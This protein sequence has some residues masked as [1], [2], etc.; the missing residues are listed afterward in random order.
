MIGMSCTQFGT[1]DPMEI[2][3][4]VSQDFKHWEIFSEDKHNVTSDF[5]TKFNAIKDSFSMKYSIHAPICDINI[6]ALNKEIRNTSVSEI[7]KTVERANMMGIRTVTVHPGIYSMVLSGVEERSVEHSRE[8]LERIDKAA[9]EYGVDVAVENMPS[10][11]VMMGQTPKALMELIDGTGLKICFDA[12]HAHTM[13]VVEEF[14]D[15]FKY[16]CG[17]RLANVHVHDNLGDKDAHLTIG[18]GNIDYHKVLS[19]LRGYRG[20]YIIESKNYSSA[21][22][23]K[24]RLETIL[25]KI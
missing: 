1:E 20:D 10:F 22:E 8:S 17:D 11:A 15:L 4:L 7:I 6:A 21:V 18:D 5:S 24:K 25:N 13:G 19:G 23:S 9:E 12:G 16:E 14:L 3:E 2:M